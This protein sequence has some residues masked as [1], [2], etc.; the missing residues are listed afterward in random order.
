M[1]NNIIIFSVIACVLIALIVIIVLTQVFTER[2][3]KKKIKL[4]KQK[5]FEN[6]K[7]LT[8]E[9][10]YKINA[11]IEKNEELLKNFVVSI[12][13]FK[14]KEIN[15][16]AKSQIKKLMKHPDYNEIFADNPYLENTLFNDNLNT[17]IETKSNLW[18]KKSIKELEYFFSLEKIYLEQDEYK[19]EYLKLKKEFKKELLLTKI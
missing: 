18:A 10:T 9:L 19:M 13:D 1:D 5:M 4:E 6:Q 2:K 14:M 11:I 16:L 12:G 17:L 3:K 15:Y 7:N 8:K